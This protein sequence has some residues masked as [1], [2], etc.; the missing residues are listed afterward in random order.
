MSST[1]LKQANQLRN[2]IRKYDHHY[3]VLDDPTIPDA[4][5][6]RLMR[7]LIKLE[8][9]HPEIITTD[10]PTQRVSGTPLD[11]FKQVKHKIPMLSLSNVFDLEELEAFDK[12][13][14]ERLK[15]KKQIKYN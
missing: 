10:S 14:K 5:Y 1:L 13:L 11:S 4:E 2:K 12:R 7:E 8:T 6:D 15:D 9:S 3:Y